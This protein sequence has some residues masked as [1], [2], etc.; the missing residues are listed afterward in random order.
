[1][2]LRFGCPRCSQD[3]SAEDTKIG[4]TVQCPR[5]KAAVVVPI[6]STL[7]PPVRNFSPQ[8]QQ[9]AKNVQP[10]LVK[11]TKIRPIKMFGK[12][13]VIGAIAV[14]AWFLYDW[15]KTPGPAP[16]QAETYTTAVLKR[17]TTFQLSYGNVTLPRG[18]Q[19]EFVS[20]NDSEVRV[21]YRGHQQSVPA[22]DIDLR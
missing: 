1:M 14:G 10:A 8:H 19:L 16:R 6:A 22:S 12:I 3:L 5:C 4:M 17:P 11:R 13:A 20:R 9:R 18:S 2:Q 7:P 15:Y 21:R